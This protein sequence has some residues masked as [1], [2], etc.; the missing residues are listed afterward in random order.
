MQRDPLFLTREGSLLNC[1]PDAG[2]GRGEETGTS[3]EPRLGLWSR[4]SPFTSVRPKL[5]IKLT[6]W[7]KV[8]QSCLTLCNSV[9]CRLPGSSVH[10]TFQV[11]ILEWVCHFLLWLIFSMQ[12][13]NPYLLHCR[14]ILYHWATWEAPSCFIAPINPGPGDHS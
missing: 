12:G 4:G 10:G 2:A 9:D 1:F 5:F 13:S 7:V 6:E 14:Q 3:G 8:A 11:R